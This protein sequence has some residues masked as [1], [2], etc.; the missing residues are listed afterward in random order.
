MKNSASFLCLLV[1]AASACGSAQD[2]REVPNTPQ[3]DIRQ[4]QKEVESSVCSEQRLAIR[5]PATLLERAK[6]KAQLL[7]LLRASLL[8]DAKGSINVVQEKEIRKLANKLR[9]EEP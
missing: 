1:L 4:S 8:N 7:V 3:L 2:F 6:V 9:K 5:V